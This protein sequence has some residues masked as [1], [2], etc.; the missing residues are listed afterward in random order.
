MK[1][2]TP[3][4]RAVPTS[5]CIGRHNPPASASVR[6]CHLGQRSSAVGHYPEGADVDGV[7]DARAT[8]KAVEH[9]PIPADDAAPRICQNGASA[10]APGGES[11]GPHDPDRVARCDGDEDE[12]VAGSRHTDRSRA[13]VQPKDRCGLSVLMCSGVAPAGSAGPVNRGRTRTPTAPRTSTPAAA[14]E[15]RAFLRRDTTAAYSRCGL[16]VRPPW[17]QVVSANVTRDR[18]GVVATLPRSVRLRAGPYHGAV[19]TPVHPSGK[20]SSLGG[21]PFRVCRGALEP[22]S[23]SSS[24][25]TRS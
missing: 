16:S 19:V 15:M 5:A 24:G 21:P 14:M 8:P 1:P 10:D 20:T 9:V 17:L 11:A 12:L 3:Q 6:K 18:A 23:R 7:V 4:M 2:G 25:T 22:G 13:A